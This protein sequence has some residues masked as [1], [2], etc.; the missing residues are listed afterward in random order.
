MKSDDPKRRRRYV[1]MLRSESTRLARLVEN[2]LVY[3][4]MGEPKP[5]LD[6]KQTSP[7]DVLDAVA[8]TTGTACEVAGK[9]LSLENRCPPDLRINTDT[10]FVVQ[11]IAN[12]VE[13]ACKYSA[14]SD[15]P[16]IWVSAIDTADGSVA[17]EVDDAGLGVPARRDRRTIFEPFRRS[18]AARN[19]QSGGLGLGLALSRYWADCLGGRLSIKRSARNGGH[20]SCFELSLPKSA[21]E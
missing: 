21:R 2:V 16:K 13:N 14:D 15:D 12:L 5:R 18:S 4:R 8:A 10:Q 7:A 19:G 3:S 20:Y 6:W 9:Q 17:F 1:E 11:I